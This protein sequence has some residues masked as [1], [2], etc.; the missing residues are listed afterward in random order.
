[1]ISQSTFQQAIG[2][3]I[4]SSIFSERTNAADGRINVG[5]I[6]DSIL[7]HAPDLNAAHFH[8]IIK[9]L[10]ADGVAA[11]YENAPVHGAAATKSDRQMFSTLTIAQAAEKASANNQDA[12]AF[13]GLLSRLA[14][15]GYPVEKDQP[16]SNT[17]L[18]ECMRAQGHMSIEDRMSLRSL[19]HLAGVLE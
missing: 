5:R 14:R 10:V 3:Q 11:D 6:R 8:S 13:R 7:K 4:M 9:G 15:V 1:M 19:C 12:A 18:T 16:I 2:F 17:R